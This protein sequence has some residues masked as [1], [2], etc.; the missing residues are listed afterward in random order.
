M[1]S[2][3]RASPLRRQRPLTLALVS[4]PSVLEPVFEETALKLARHVGPGFVVDRCQEADDVLYLAR[5][6]K[7]RGY[8]LTRLDLHGHG[9]G[10]EFKLGDELLFASDGTGYALAR[11]LAESLAPKAALRLLGCRT[12]TEGVWPK[13]DGAKRSGGKLLRDL[14]R[15]LGEGRRVWGTAGYLGP[16]DLLGT[17]LTHRAR[18]LLRTG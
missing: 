5:L 10:G 9:A 2:Q 12:A 8:A 7:N 13:P 3:Q 11:A 14:Q 17:G 4:Y 15:L 1:P 18:R 6:W 16:R